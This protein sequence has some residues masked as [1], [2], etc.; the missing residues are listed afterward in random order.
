MERAPSFFARIGLAFSAFFR[1]LGSP[2][3]ARVVRD[4][5]P[6]LEPPPA[7]EPKSAPEPEPEAPRIERAPTDAAMQLLGL[8]QRE[9]R[10]VDF[11]QEDVSAFSDADIGAAAR[12][13]H[14]GCAKALKDR[15]TLEPLHAAEEGSRVTVESGF[16]P[17]KIRL[18]GN[19]RG[20]APFTG[21]LQHRGWRAATLELPALAE[22]HDPAVLMPAE[23][24]L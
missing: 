17:A 6:A 7:P 21:E 2:D 11:L 13:V 9:G 24:E 5:P 18:T 16:D 4:G 15:L 12:V 8:L 3:F 23:V 22:G 19:V 20:E 10:F 1:T 14:E